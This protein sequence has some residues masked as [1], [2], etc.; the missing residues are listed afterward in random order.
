ME[1]ERD[2]SVEPKPNENCDLAFF[3]DAAVACGSQEPR[4]RDVAKSIKPR[5]RQSSCRWPPT[6]VMM[7]PTSGAKMMSMLR[8]ILS[9]LQLAALILHKLLRSF[10]ATS[11]KLRAG[12][13]VGVD[14]GSQGTA[15]L[16]MSQQVRQECGT[17]WLRVV[18]GVSGPLWPAD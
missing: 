2:M 9:F 3:R 14:F 8:S 6:R 12:Y 13:L 17:G 1:Q 5:P 10:P 11:D 15:E 18:T 7:N 4:S 16:G